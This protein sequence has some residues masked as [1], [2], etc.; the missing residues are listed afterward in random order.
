MNTIK[1]SRVEVLS[2]VIDDP[3][4]LVELCRVGRIHCLVV[5][6][7]IDGEEQCSLEHLAV[8]FCFLSK[9]VENTEGTNVMRVRRTRFSA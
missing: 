2:F 4:D 8:G 6:D 7:M 1:F 9:A 5:L 3:L